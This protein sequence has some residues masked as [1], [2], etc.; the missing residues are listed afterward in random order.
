V[1]TKTL[2]P[3]PTAGGTLTPQ[4]LVLSVSATLLFATG[5]LERDASGPV[6]VPNTT[7]VTATQAVQAAQTGIEC[8]CNRVGAYVAPD[9]GKR[10]TTNRE[11]ASP[12]NVYQLTATTVGSTIN[13][14]IRRGTTVVA[15]FSGLPSTT[16]WGF[17]PN[18]DRFVFHYL[19]GVAPNQMHNVFVHNLAASGAPLV[20]SFSAPAGANRI[21]FSPRGRHVLYSWVVGSN[22]TELVIADAVTGATRYQTGFNFTTPPGSPGNVFGT[23]GW[24]FSPDDSDRT[25]AYYYITGQNSAMWNVVNLSGSGASA[26]VSSEQR[27]TTG[28]WRFSPCGDLLAESKRMSST[29]VWVSLRATLDGS[30]VPNSGRYVPVASISF[31]STLASH[32]VTVDGTDYTPLASNTADSACY[33]AP[34]PTLSTVH[35]YPTIVAGGGTSLGTVVLSSA[36]PTGGMS[37]TLSSSSPAAASVPASVIIPAGSTSATFTV[38]TS[39]VVA[40]TAVS[41]SATVGGVTKSASM[42]VTA[43]PPAIRSLNVTPTTLTYADQA[44]GTTSVTKTVVVSNNG[45]TPVLISGISTSGDFAQTNNCPVAPMDLAILQACTIV[46]SFTPTTTG[47]RTGTVSITSDATNGPHSVALSGNGYAPVILASVSPTSLSFG[48]A[49]LGLSPIRK[50][51]TLSSTGNTP[52]TVST[53]SISGAHPWD[54][55]TWT[56]E[57]SGATVPPGSSCRV[58]VYFEPMATGTRT[59]SVTIMHNGAGGP[60]VVPMSGRGVANGGYVP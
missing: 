59:A 9:T 45:N 28:F 55:Y 1:H 43:P 51:I 35:L 41:I 8:G 36:A 2:A 12:H 19:S 50:W 4:L 10:I 48:S 17:S 44:V 53:V 49:T 7:A 25:F 34:P 21:V 29:Q 37:A 24:G 42:T 56:D 16:N 13:L 39:P 32:I 27:T 18:D 52:L 33:V 31:K 5:C 3:R 23:L 20:K 54:F 58:E 6:S 11:G 60:S 47:V 46:V 30:V 26:L 15:Q 40:N 57:C 38:Q 14:Q 22:H